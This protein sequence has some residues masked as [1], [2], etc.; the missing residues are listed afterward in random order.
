MTI[1]EARA[2]TLPA[3]RRAR[4]WPPVP[5]WGLAPGIE[6]KAEASKPRKVEITAG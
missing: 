4:L 6:P 1:R 5:A 2:M 3:R